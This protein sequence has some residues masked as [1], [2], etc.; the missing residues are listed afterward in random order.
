MQVY[1]HFEIPRTGVCLLLE[2]TSINYLLILLQFLRRNDLS[3]EFLNIDNLHKFQKHFLPPYFPPVCHLILTLVTDLLPYIIPNYALAIVTFVHIH[4]NMGWGNQLHVLVV[5]LR[6]LNIFFFD[7]PNYAALRPPFLASVARLI[8][9][10][11]NYSL[12]LAIDKSYL[13][14]VL[15]KGSAELL[16]E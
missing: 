2:L 3:K 12:L 15:L 14:N 7:C 4:L 10:G 16:T 8:S 5:N 9:P 13:L 11:I 6:L 1:I